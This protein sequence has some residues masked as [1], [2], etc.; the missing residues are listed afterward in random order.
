MLFFACGGVEKIKF[1]LQP[2]APYNLNKHIRRTAGNV[3]I[4][5]HREFD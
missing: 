5:F 3:T 4:T 1:V 2:R